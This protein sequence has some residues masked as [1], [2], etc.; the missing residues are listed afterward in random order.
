[1]FHIASHTPRLC[2]NVQL[3]HSVQ[4]L[5]NKIVVQFTARLIKEMKAKRVTVS[6]VSSPLLLH[7]RRIKM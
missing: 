6:N 2:L 3:R 7:K 1:M 4:L 5:I